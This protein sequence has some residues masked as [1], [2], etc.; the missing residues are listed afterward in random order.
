MA[1]V[2]RYGSQRW[3][4]E[5]KRIWE[6]IRNQ[7]WSV[8]YAAAS[9]VVEMRRARLFGDYSRVAECQEMWKRFEKAAAVAIT[10]GK[11]DIEMR[12]IYSRLGQLLTPEE[13]NLLQGKIK[14]I[15]EWVWDEKAWE[16]GRIRPPEGKKP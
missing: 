9:F 14:R 3:K 1:R 13:G 11:G 5:E 2:I 10:S 12:L 8:H 16:K 15:E 6:T 7:N 4:D